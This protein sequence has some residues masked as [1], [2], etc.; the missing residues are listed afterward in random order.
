MQNLVTFHKT[1]LSIIREKK[2]LKGW[3]KLRLLGSRELDARFWV[4]M[5]S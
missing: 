1:G 4:E 2:N 5:K 3:W